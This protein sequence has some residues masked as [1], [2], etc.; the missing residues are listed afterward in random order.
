MF[1]GQSAWFSTSV[2]KNV[3]RLWVDNGGR[4]SDLGDAQFIFSQNTHS[5]DTLSVFD[6][7]AYVEEH[8]AVFHPNYIKECVKRGGTDQVILGK[9]FFPPGD[10]QAIARNQLQYQWDL[11]GNKSDGGT[12]N[13]SD[14]EDPAPSS[15]VVL[16]NSKTVRRD[17]VDT[18]Q[19]STSKPRCQNKPDGASENQTRDNGNSGVDVTQAHNNHTVPGQS[20]GMAH[21]ENN[22][23]LEKR[24]LRRS[25]RHTNQNTGT[26]TDNVRLQHDD[27]RIQHDLRHK[28]VK[29]AEIN[30]TGSTSR[31]NEDDERKKSSDSKSV[32]NKKAP[33]CGSGIKGYEKSK[34]LH[35]HVDKLDSE[36][37][38]LEDLAK[39][40]GDLQ[41]F[42]VGKNGCQ[43][44]KIT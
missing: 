35:Q 41:D 7:E 16:N 31:D 26:V 10:V 43:L 3:K 38:R 33:A 34:R 24:S 22:K 30:K 28:T 25:S 19:A 20:L 27:D 44:V 36:I 5:P 14:D 42:V 37:L 12:T 4:V 11:D 40:T 39:V 18:Q 15:N 23:Q 9:Y 13:S 1:K 6:S 17:I 8:L 2:G 29:S 32:G 21:S